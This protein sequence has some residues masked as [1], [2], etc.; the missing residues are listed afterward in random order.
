MR[1]FYAFCRWLTFGF[2]S[3]PM[4]TRYF[5]VTN[6]PRTGGVLLVSNHQSFFDPP[7]VGMCLPRECHYMARET[8]FK[9]DWF[10]RFIRKFNAFPVKR[11]SADVGAI[12]ETL[13]LLK[14][15]QAVLVFP[16]GT[17]TIDGTVGE[18]HAGVVLLARRANVPI[19]PTLVLG[20]F[21]AW[22]RQ[23]KVPRPH[24]LIVSFSRPIPATTL[25]AMDDQQ[26][27]DLV[28]GRIT[29]MQR[30]Y[31]RHGHIAHR[32][33]PLPAP[34]GPGVAGDSAAATADVNAAPAGEAAQ[35]VASAGK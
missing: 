3:L 35:P 5:G 28:R 21:E 16:E 32:L 17:R 9:P 22:P 10:G 25:K 1:P 27:V 11:G 13:R 12:K 23:A 15:Q 14:K 6:V 30:R 34:R 19:V 18:L 7:L 29:A 31:S 8:L 26:C 4:R 24:P 2:F 33:Q 20:A